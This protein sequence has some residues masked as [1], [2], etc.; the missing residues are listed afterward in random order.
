MALWDGEKTHEGWR[1]NYM[2]AFHKKKKKKPTQVEAKATQA[3]AT[4]S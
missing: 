4:I 1:T 3:E 2:D